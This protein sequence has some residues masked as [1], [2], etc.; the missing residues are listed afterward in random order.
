MSDSRIGVH[1]AY[2]QSEQAWNAGVRWQRVLFYW[3]AIQP[4]WNGQALP[5]RYVNDAIIQNE[6][7]RG[8]RIVGVIGNP[9]RWATGD[10]SVPK[11]LTLP[12]DDPNNNWTRFVRQL[13]TGYAGRI[14]SWIVWNEPD[15]RPGQPGST[16]NGSEA[17]YWLLLKS[18]YKTIKAA[19]PR[20]TVAFAGTTYWADARDGRKLF[21]ERVLEQGAR[22][23]E[24]KANGFFFDVVPFHIYSSPYK[25]YE[26]AN[27]Y[28]EVLKRFGLD[29]PIWLNETNV[30][31]ADDP[32]SQVPRAGARASLE[33]QASFVI[34]T[35]ALSRA[36]GIER[37]QFYK[38]Q[39]GPIEG[40]EPY[41]LIRN[42]RSVRPAYVALQTAAKY[43]LAD[44]KV[45]YTTVDGVAQVV[46]DQGRRRT[47]VA[48]A[49]GPAATPAHLPPMGTTATLVDKYGLERPLPLP[50]ESGEYKITLAGATANTASNARDYIIGGDPVIVVENGVGDPIESPNAIFYGLTGHNV[51]GA[52]L[53]YFRR[54][55]GL[56]TFG[57][58]ISRPF[59]LLGHDVQLFQRQ[60]IELLP[61][62][63]VGTLN[64]LDDEFLPYTRFNGAVIPPRD[65]ALTKTAPAPGSRD[66][67]PAL[68]RWIAANA[69]DSWEQL[70]VGFKHRLDSTVTLATAFPDGKGDPALLPGLNLE[71]WGVP[72]SQPARDPANH[73]FVYQRFQ[74]GVMHFDR[75]TGATQGLLLATYLRAVLTGN[76]L[77]ADLEAQARG[78]RLYRQYDRAKPASTARPAELAESDLTNAFEREAPAR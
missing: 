8:Y 52:R 49:T 77:P 68:Q 78:S 32:H 38:M 66:Y 11:N 60:A 62:G 10:G 7:S 58:P 61:G 31:P 3:D 51:E 76:E 43:L 27:A 39:D 42:D 55:G 54:R 53:D 26:V 37:V 48:W 44:G 63:R 56:A 40:G 14:D 24:A 22:D 19:N 6:L 20:A 64:L 15:I 18:A 12:V 29:K 71:L 70:P 67:G 45:S 13:A 69:P 2:L 16:W 9:P 4:D 28:R 59:R 35:L 21:L 1:D 47:T 36:A 73:D 50:T 72:T 25:V 33:E 75:A 17:E 30:V 41:G 74:R 5:N 46:I 23:P 65:E 57:Y 34:Q